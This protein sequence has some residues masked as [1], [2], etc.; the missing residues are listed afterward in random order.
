MSYRK[1]EDTPAKKRRRLP[2]K[3]II[4]RSG[5]NHTV[6][7]TSANSRRSALSAV[8]L[9]LFTEL[10]Q[11]GLDLPALTKRLKLHQRSARDFL[12]ALVALGLLN[13]HGDH[14]ANTPATD[15]FLDRRKPAYV[16]GLLEMANA[17]PSNPSRCDLQKN[18]D[19]RRYFR[20]PQGADSKSSPRSG[21]GT[22]WR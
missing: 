18:C 21:I 1:G 22:R 19:L 10:A 11:G 17:R 13:R 15:L 7:P 2:H 14:Y 5:P 9:G 4:E 3:V 16:G 12:D 8:E 6:T 20:L